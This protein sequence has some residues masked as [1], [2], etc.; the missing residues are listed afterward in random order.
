MVPQLKN[1]WSEKLNL[2]LS[3]SSNLIAVILGAFMKA[4]PLNFVIFSTTNYKSLNT[5]MKNINNQPWNDL[6]ILEFNKFWK[7][8]RNN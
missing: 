7:L 3:I 4:N 2:D 1:Y 8:E 5:I 6:D